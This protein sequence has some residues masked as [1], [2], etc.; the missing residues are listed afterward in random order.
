MMI[1]SQDVLDF[2]MSYFRKSL[3]QAKRYFMTR[4][5]ILMIGFYI[6]DV[7]GALRVQSFDMAVILP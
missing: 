7:F 1:P 3:L 5:Y 4:R 6:L 2:L